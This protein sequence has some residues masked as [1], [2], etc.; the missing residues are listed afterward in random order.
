[1]TSLRTLSVSLLITLAGCASIKEYEQAEPAIPRAFVKVRPEVSSLISSVSM[2]SIVD[3][4]N[5]CG[6]PAVNLKRAYRRSDGNPLVTDLNI[7]GF[8][9][10]SGKRVPFSAVVLSDKGTCGVWAS[11]LPEAGKT[12]EIRMKGNGKVFD[13][14][15][16]ECAFTV[17]RLIPEGSAESSEAG[18]RTEVC[19]PR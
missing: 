7:D 11:F 6:D 3:E 15:T 19:R 17:S 13:W 12:Y 16:A 2:I 9:V 5:Y 18:Y 1:M 4:I 10:P 14:E 8:W